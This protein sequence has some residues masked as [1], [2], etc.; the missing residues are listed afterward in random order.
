MCKTRSEDQQHYSDRKILKIAL[1]L[2]FA[3]FVIGL[4]AGILVQSTGLI[5]DS[6]DMLADS[7]AYFIGLLAIDRSQ[8]FRSVAAKLSGIILLIL[9]MWVLIEVIKRTW[10]GSFPDSITMII[11]ASISFVVNS[12]VLLLLRPLKNKEIHLKATWIFT[13][14]DIIANLGV[15]LAGVLVY[16]TKSRY[17]DLIAGF[18]IGIYVMK[19]AVEI[20][21]LR[22]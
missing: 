21:R 12:S 13:R 18:A 19:E 22:N 20:I 17:P 1:I 3:M 10:F 8:K 4:T 2:N 14:A 7:L 11:I 16:L 9:G 6:L 5:A 15:I